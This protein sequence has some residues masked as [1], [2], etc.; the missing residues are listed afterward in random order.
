MTKTKIATLYDEPKSKGFVN[1]LIQSY[2]PLYKSK[3]VWEFTDGK[4]YHRCS[5]CGHELIDLGTVIGRM[6]ESDD[7]MKDFIEQMRKEIDGEKIEYEDKAIIKHVTHGAILGWQGDKTT[8]FL[9]QGCIKELLDLVTNGL[10]MGDKNISYQVNKNRRAELFNHF[11][12]SPNLNT[13]EK[14]EVQEIQKKVEKKH[15]AT[16]GDL[17][18]LQQL[19]EKMEKEESESK[20]QKS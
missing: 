10:M 4:N 16:F 9:C 18:V 15:V 2:L 13:D 6:H 7:Y 19:K 5:I 17:T 12:E 11:V 3:K 8:T 1:H 20:I 14:K